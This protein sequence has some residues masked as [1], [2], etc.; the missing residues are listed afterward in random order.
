VSA[1]GPDEA[2]TPR[3][4]R[5]DTGASPRSRRRSG[6]GR[7]RPAPRT[8]PAEARPG[9]PP[10]AAAPDE[11]ARPEPGPEPRHE[12]GPQ[13]LPDPGPESAPETAPQPRPERSDR[14][15]TPAWIP[16]L[17]LVVVAVAALFTAFS[18]GLLGGGGDDGDAPVVDAPDAAPGD[19]QPA[20]TVVTTTEGPDGTE[21]AN[22]ALLAVDREAGEGTI[23]L[24]PPATIADVPG[25]GSFRL[26][27]AFD[28]GGAGLV[29]VSLDN[30]LGV[31]ADAVVTVSEAGWA[32]WLDPLGGVEVDLATPVVDRAEDGS[33]T[34]LLPAGPQTLGGDGLATALTFRSDDE[35]Q[36]DQLPRV[37]AVLLALLDRFRADPPALDALFTGEVT[38]LD[39]VGTVGAPDGE[40]AAD[41]D[42]VRT[43]LAELATAREQDAVTTLTLPVSPLGTGTEDAYRPD[44]DRISALVD[45]RLAASRPDPGVAGG[46]TLQLLN[47]NGVPGVGAEVAAVLQ[48]AG[49]R[50][51]LTGNADRFTYD[52][53]RI[54][55]YDEQPDTLAAARDVRDRLGVGEIERSGTPQSVVDLTI[56]IGRDFPA[57]GA[58]DTP[59]SVEGV[60]ADGPDDEDAD[61]E[62]EEEGEDE[63]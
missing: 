37:Q 18:I 32:S 48:P 57:G 8:R 40:A 50:V 7:D 10:P 23:L 54:V 35:S 5:A 46:R 43:V 45:D 31:R 6:R 14:P 59:D 63:G 53:T 41:T 42:L 47:G 25:H 4:R 28:F 36:L 55:V 1:D 29:G 60:P 9:S 34:T 27:E 2:A 26:G 61:D 39:V 51:L 11:G 52:V 58:P 12:P 3:P 13:A 15:D 30:L 38:D 17:V 62:D 24:V 16:L 19:P 22:I 20:V 49:Y 21:V 44:A 56:V 33:G